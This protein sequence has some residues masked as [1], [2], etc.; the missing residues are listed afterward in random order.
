MRPEAPSFGKIVGPWR[1]G[2]TSSGRRSPG[3][4]RPEKNQSRLIQRELKSTSVSPKCRGLAEMMPLGWYGQCQEFGLGA[5]LFNKMALLA[6]I[7]AEGVTPQV[8]T[9]RSFCTLRCESQKCV[10]LGWNPSHTNKHT[11]PTKHYP[12]CPALRK[13]KLGNIGLP[14][15]VVLSTSSKKGVA[16]CCPNFHSWI[17]LAS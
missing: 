11:S 6:E 7:L 4:Q 5:Q 15:F 16:A 10:K 1:D 17:E 14:C 9:H 8:E 12:E 13:R 2:S 3:S